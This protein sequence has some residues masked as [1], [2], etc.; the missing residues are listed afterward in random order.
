MVGH[1]LGLN[2][3]F[4]IMTEFLVLSRD[5]DSLFRDMVLRLQAVAWSRHSIFMS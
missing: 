3:G 5:R 2:M 4:L 1:G